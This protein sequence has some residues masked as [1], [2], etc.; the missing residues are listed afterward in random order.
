MKFGCTFVGVKLR[1]AAEVAALLEGV[2][3]ESLW[4][5]EHLALPA[6]MPATYPYSESGLAPI[7][8]DTPCYD[9]WALLSFLACATTTIRLATNVYILPLRHPL[10]TARSVV[11]LDRLSG[12]RVTLGIGLG[13]LQP[14]FEWTRISFSDR[15]RLT[16]EAIPLLRRLWTDDVIEHHGEHFNVGPLKFQPKPF[17]QPIPIEIG[18]TSPVALRRVGTLGDGW[19]EHGSRSLDELRVRLAKVHEARRAAGRDEL[20]FDVTVAADP[21]HLDRVEPLRDA[22]VTR[23]VVS[24]WRAA[25]KPAPDRIGEWATRVM[26]DLRARFGP[27]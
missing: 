10:Q 7:E 18:G 1:E 4:V 17:Q 23:V 21:D 25:V 16:Y 13:W 15:G 14:E 12:G 6:T 19:I 8:P 27:Q 2:G 3:F 20:P 5:P 9:P 22:G 26:A 11:T 24:P